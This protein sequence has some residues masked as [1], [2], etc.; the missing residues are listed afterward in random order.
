[1]TIKNEIHNEI[2]TET[3][4]EIKPQ[5]QNEIQEKS[6][7]L[8][9]TQT[10]KNSPSNAEI[11]L[12][13]FD[14]LNHEYL[15]L[16]KAENLIALFNEYNLYPSNL[17]DWFKN[18][19]NGSKYDID[20]GDFAADFFCDYELSKDDLVLIEEQLN[21][22]MTNLQYEIISE[23]FIPVISPED[24]NQLDRQVVFNFK[25]HNINIAIIGAVWSYGTYEYDSDFYPVKMK[26]KTITVWEK[27]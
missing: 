16:R 7:T 9:Q 12:D 11:I 10:D 4:N 22:F 6:E 14:K 5:E 1:M 23:E 26:R 27:V 25:P 8:E 19:T 18:Q 17:E 21:I 24:G 20:F 2:H 15:K 13:F 3:Q